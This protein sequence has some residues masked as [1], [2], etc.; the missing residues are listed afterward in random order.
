MSLDEDAQKDRSNPIQ[1]STS[2]GEIIAY[3]RYGHEWIWGVLLF[4]C[5]IDW[6]FPASTFDVLDHNMTSEGKDPFK[7]EDISK[8]EIIAYDI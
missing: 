8:G 5:I 1:S 6:T 4:R 2:E 7:I 3:D